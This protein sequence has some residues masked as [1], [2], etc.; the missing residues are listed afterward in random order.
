MELKGERMLI[1]ESVEATPT[2]HAT[3]APILA[4]GQASYDRSD[5]AAAKKAG[6]CTTFIR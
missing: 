2:N 1:S 5:I 3:C 6:V 4:R